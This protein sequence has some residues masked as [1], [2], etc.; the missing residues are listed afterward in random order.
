VGDEELLEMLA[1]EANRRVPPMKK[2]LKKLAKG[3]EPDPDAVEEIRVEV[4]GLKGAALVL[5]EQR[6]GQLAER[7]EQLLAANTADGALD[8]EFAAPLTEAMDAFQA[9][10]DAAAAGEPEP[11]SVAEALVA[12]P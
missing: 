8:P 4:H 12:L 5:G 7:A 9:G 6:L 2:S 10:A 11:P 3:S 1:A